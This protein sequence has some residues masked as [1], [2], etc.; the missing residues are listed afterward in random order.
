LNDAQL[1]AFQ[2]PD[3]IHATFLEYWQT[4]HKRP[5]PAYAQTEEEIQQEMALQRRK[6]R[7]QM[8]NALSEGMANVEVPRVLDSRQRDVTLER[9]IDVLEHL[10]DDY[11]SSIVI[12]RHVVP[13]ITRSQHGALSGDSAESLPLPPDEQPDE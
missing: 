8:I 6:V 7:E 1:G 4:F 2:L 13:L 11:Q 5:S 9:L 10:R 3:N 12:P